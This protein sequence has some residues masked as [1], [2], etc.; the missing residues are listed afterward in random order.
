VRTEIVFVDSASTDKTA[1]IA[2]VYPISVLRLRPDQPL[3]PAAGRF[4]G[5]HATSGDFVLFLDGDMELC[6]GWLDK[7]LELME[8][9]PDVGAVTGRVLD[10]LPEDASQPVCQPSADF[11]DTFTEVRHGGGAALYRRSVL[12]QVGTFNPFLLSDEEP[13]LCLRIR[14]AGYRVI[15]A[16]HPISYHYSAPR[17]AIST[18]LARWRRNLYKG[19]GQTMRYHLGS[20]LLWAY[21]KER[22]FALVT[23]VGVLLGLLG[24]AASL[25]TGHWGWF[26]GWIVLIGGVVAMDAWRKH[27]LYRALFSLLHRLLILDGTIRGFWLPSLPPSQ[28][29]ARVDVLKQAG[30]LQKAYDE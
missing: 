24:F 11:E 4:V 14:H 27:S 9:L 17:T 6:A 28:Y 5:Y 10:C 1:D 29:P 21:L 15:R 8:R 22:G 30:E 26:A 13:E 2:C 12:E 25:I 18:L 23:G 3:S 19:Y 20:P 16:S 7:A